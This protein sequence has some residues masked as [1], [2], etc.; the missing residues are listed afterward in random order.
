MPPGV[1]ILAGPTASG[2]TELALALA[3]R[4]GAEIVGADSRQIYRGMTIGTAA[5]TAEQMSLVRHHLIGFLDPHVRYSA[6]AFVD[7]ALRVIEAARAPTLVVG[8]TGFYVRAL[9][10]DVA[11][12]GERDE[13]LRARL[14][15]E[16][17]LHPPE[18]LHAWL[19]ARD[20]ER[21]GAIEPGDRYRVVRALEIALGGERSREQRN[22]RTAGIPYRKAFLEIAPAEL[23]RR[24]AARVDRM[25]DEGL[26]DEAERVGAGA[27][28]ADAVGYP[29]A[30]AYLRG[31]ATRAELRAQLVR[32]TRRYAKRQATWF[33]SEPQLVHV[34]GYEDAERLARTLPGWN[35]CEE[36]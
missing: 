30:L 31:F 19:A 13:G 8:G 21:A 12:A 15:R 16:A 33:R 26:V 36:G 17:Q 23:E 11:L 32:A 25:L 34:A 10:G 28:A 24:I 20:P 22:L 29:Q 18:V 4:F 14:A 27:V 35:R 6:A 3:R 5:P 1:L 2:K 9:A 7:D